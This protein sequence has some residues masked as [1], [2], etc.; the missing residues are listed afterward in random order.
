MEN[1]QWEMVIAEPNYCVPAVLEMVLK[2]YDITSLTQND[3]A[4]QLIVIPA[5]NDVDHEMWGTL[6]GRD[7]I[8]RFFANNDLPLY[9]EFVSINYFMDEMDLTDKIEILLERNVTIICGYNYSR[10]YEEDYDIFRHVSIIVSISQDKKEIELLDPGPVNAGFKMVQAY[11][12]FGAI[13]DGHDGLWC[14]RRIGET[15]Y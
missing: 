14:I 15:I 6:I 1:K 10:L 9:E 3:I 12:L 5:D 2:H 13:K 7:S 8:N 11:S 4:S